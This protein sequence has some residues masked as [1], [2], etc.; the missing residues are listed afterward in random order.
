MFQM[1]PITGYRN[2]ISLYRSE[3]ELKCVFV[4]INFILLYNF[5]QRQDV[6]I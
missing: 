2:R 1:G 3:A 4:G 5:I 6:E